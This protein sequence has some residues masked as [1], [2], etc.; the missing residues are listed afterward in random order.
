MLGTTLAYVNGVP[1]RLQA[2][3]IVRGAD[4]NTVWVPLEAVN[5]Y[6]V[7]VT[8]DYYTEGRILTV[9]RD[10]VNDISGGA[11]PIYTDISFALHGDGGSEHI[12]EGSLPE[13][14]L[15][16]SDPRPSADTAEDSAAPTN[17]DENTVK[18]N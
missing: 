12:I 15:E 8:A 18:L 10:T 14:V 16:S 2:P 11:N 6:F 5:T 1:V 3:T 9:A 13:S 17:D 7:G 4:N